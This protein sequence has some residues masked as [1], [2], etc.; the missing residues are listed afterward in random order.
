MV[1]S[2]KR[3]RIV[4]ALSCLLVYL[5]VPCRV[6]V[7]CNHLFPPDLRTSS[8][9]AMD[10]AE[11]KKLK[12]AK[13]ANSKAKTVK[14]LLAASNSVSPPSSPTHKKPGLKKKPKDGSTG[15]PTGSVS[16]L[17][18]RVDSG[19]SPNPENKSVS[20]PPPPSLLH[21]RSG[22]GKRESSS[23]AASTASGS[24]RS[25]W[26]TFPS[27]HHQATSAPDTW[28]SYAN[29]KLVFNSML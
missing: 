25:M 3:E 8:E 19:V 22:G 10:K 29:S 6:A 9:K 13:T 16:V 1:L 5:S 21:K 2:P 11:K 15:S 23:S 17:N 7:T 26:W 20:P 27:L 14:D 28:V 24:V 4:V 18:T 12:K